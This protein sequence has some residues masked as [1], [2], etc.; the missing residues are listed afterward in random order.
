MTT[1]DNV[2]VGTTPPIP[3]ATPSRGG[4]LV[5]AGLGVVA[6]SLSL[7]MTKIAVRGLDPTVA[8]LGRAAV[9]A[10]FAAMVVALVRPARPNRHQIISLLVVVA[11]V[12]IGFPLLTAYALRHTESLH[13]SVVN[14]ILPL[15]TAG[16]AVVRAGE[17]PSGRYWACSCLGFAAV[18]GF[19]IS[20]GGGQLH[21]A[22]VLLVLAVAAAAAGYAEGALL[23]RDLGGWQV[24]CW[25]LLIGAP[26]TFG[27]TAAAAFRTG[28][29]ASPGEWVAFGYTAL[30][31][32]FL[33]FFA[34]YAG[35]VRAGIARGGQLQLAQP[36]LSLLWGWPLLGEQLSV[37]AAF[38]IA[39][40]L[41]AV[42]LGRRTAVSATDHRGRDRT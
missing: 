28:L 20:E 8:A 2:I 7:P 34:W 42:A 1:E 14:G 26:L 27:I 13:G 10:A 15:A 36:A 31:S 19:V 11:G 12:V 32:M 39:I 24:I 22:D 18:V 4:G 5:L 37:A 3:L 29:S 35:L 9:A 33:G 30:F 6:F 17:R 21:L 38:T 23:A 41:L 40:V 25:A 16:L